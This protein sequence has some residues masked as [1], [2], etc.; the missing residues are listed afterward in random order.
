MLKRIK[1]LD[2]VIQRYKSG[3]DKPIVLACMIQLPKICMDQQDINL[4]AEK[5]RNLCSI[6]LSCGDRE[7]VGEKSD[8]EAIGMDIESWVV[9]N[10]V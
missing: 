3:D 9:E 6:Q 10:E 4:I 7:L 5:T 2:K 1:I 8:E